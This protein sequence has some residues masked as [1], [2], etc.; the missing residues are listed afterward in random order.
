MSKEIKENNKLFVDCK[1]QVSQC[2]VNS[3]SVDVLL[4]I[5]PLKYRRSS[6]VILKET[7][8]KLLPSLKST[9]SL[10]KN[11]DSVGNTNS[12]YQ[13]NVPT[14]DESNDCIL[15]EPKIDIIDLTNV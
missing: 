1:D 10:Y 2:S 5:E 9:L 4:N 7:N 3:N 15:I 14:Q 13:L 11:T 12:K 8:T 6:E